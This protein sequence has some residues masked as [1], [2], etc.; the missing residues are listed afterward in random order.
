MICRRLSAGGAGLSGGA[1]EGVSLCLTRLLRRN[2]APANSA[3]TW[4][5]AALRWTFLTSA[6]A[7]S[8]SAW[9]LA[10]SAWA[11]GP[12]LASSA[13]MARRISAESMTFS[14]DRA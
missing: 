9:I 7:L 14:A 3:L 2:A 1:G 8:T 4:S 12:R 6:M 13:A 10:R 5:M 11:K